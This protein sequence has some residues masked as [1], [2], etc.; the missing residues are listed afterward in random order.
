MHNSIGTQSNCFILWRSTFFNNLY[1]FGTEI[2]DSVEWPRMKIMTACL[3]LNTPPS[4]Q[5][6]A[7]GKKKQILRSASVVVLNNVLLLSRQDAFGEKT[8]GNRKRWYRFQGAWH[9]D[10]HGFTALCL[11]M[12]YRYW[13][14]ADKSVQK[15]W[16]I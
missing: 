6:L 4:F 3:I 5:R 14:L 16:K 12:L 9:S 15:Q 2:K 10:A 1:C 13:P 11:T 7:K 8:V